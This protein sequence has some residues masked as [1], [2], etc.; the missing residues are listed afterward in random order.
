MRLIFLSYVAILISASDV[1]QYSPIGSD[2]AATSFVDWIAG[3][4]AKGYDEVLVKPGTYNVT[5]SDQ[6]YPI[7]LTSVQNFT[8]W[9]TGV[10]LVFEDPTNA[11][12]LLDQCSNV[13]IRGLTT[14]YSVPTTSQAQVIQISNSSDQYF[15][16]LRIV[17]GYPTEY[18]LGAGYGYVFSNKTLLPYGPS[19]N[20]ELY[21]S[22]QQSLSADNRTQRWQVSKDDVDNMIAV[23][24]YVAVRGYYTHSSTPTNVPTYLSSMSPSTNVEDTVG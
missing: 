2:F 3:S 17:D 20:T 23:G 9:F 18:F 21:P 13:A 14:T 11:G 12:I 4:I 24:D 7:V 22:S 5:S 8:I 1:P 16:D 19:A 15:I 10:L 6:T